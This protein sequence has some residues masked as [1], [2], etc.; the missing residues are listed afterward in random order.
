MCYQLYRKQKVEVKYHNIKDSNS[1]L[2]FVVILDIFSLFYYENHILT[3][4]IE[5]Q[6][7]LCCITCFKRNDPTNLNTSKYIFRSGI[8]KTLITTITKSGGWG[9]GGGARA[10]KTSQHLWWIKPD[11]WDYDWICTIS[12]EKL[13]AIFFI[14]TRQ[15]Y[16]ETQ[17]RA[18]IC[19]PR[20]RLLRRIYCSCQRWRYNI[21]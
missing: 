18:Q 21:S 14:E 2:A 9:L 13:W 5:L 10:Q 19:L 3:F 6:T 11:S 20:R 16:V 1:K 15:L 4:C 17:L 8:T 7:T 12:S